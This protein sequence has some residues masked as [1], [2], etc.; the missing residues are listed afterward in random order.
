MPLQRDSRTGGGR[1]AM[2]VKIDTACRDRRLQRQRASQ[3]CG[4][5]S[6]MDRVLSRTEF[7]RGPSSLTD[8]VLQRTEFTR[9]REVGGT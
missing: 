4:P 3:S 9:I 5:S 2:Q 8:R 1:A 6:P 7:S